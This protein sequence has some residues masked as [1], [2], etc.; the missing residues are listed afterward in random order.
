MLEGRQRGWALAA[1]GML[2]V[3]TDSY[4]VRLAD[5]DGWS[6]A[7]MVSCL[8]LPLQFVLQRVV[9]GGDV[10]GRF[11]ESPRGL[12]TVGLLSG[13]SQIC[14]ITAITRTDVSN[15]VV[16]V[17]SSP[18]IAAVVGRVFFGERTNRRTWIAIGITVCGV[19]IVVSSSI[20]SPN[21]VGD[22]LAM[23]AVSAFA[24]NMNVWRRFKTQSRF[25]GLSIAA[26]VTILI[27][28]WFADPFGH[29]PTVYLAVVGMGLIFNPL[30][31]LCHT[32]APRHAPASEVAL[33]TPVETLAAS[34]W[35]WIA[36]SEQP[37]TR[38]FIGGAVILLGLLYGT[39]RREALASAG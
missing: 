34:A 31:R 16:I 17:A 11:R 19:V 36:F 15:V 14:F 39:S 9:E 5:I 37:S 13:I 3:S 2:L 25:V 35:A 38:T 28:V 12:A 27:S 20:G 10:I 8:S 21:L 24:V 29:S 26:A 23:V 7:F 18:I 1:L 30:G 4:L 32:S 22:L 33:F 6:M